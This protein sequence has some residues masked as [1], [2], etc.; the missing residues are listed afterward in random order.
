[1]L[2]PEQLDQFPDNLVTLY[3]KLEA[4]IIA[5]ISRRLARYDYFIPSAEF[6]YKKALEMGNIHDEILKKMERLT[7]KRK[8]E[9]EQLMK[10]AG[11]ETIKV[12]DEIY[13]LAGLKPK[14]I[15]QSPALM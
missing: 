4:D 7:G 15:S 5:D 13:Q 9:I 11:Y 12:D 3:G 1:M 2:T 14:P 10:E 6:Q 8:R